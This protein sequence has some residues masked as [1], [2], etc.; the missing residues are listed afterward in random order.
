MTSLADQLSALG[1]Q[2]ASTPLKDALLLGFDTETTGVG[3]TDAIV[4]AS[5]VLRDPSTGFDGDRRGDW[6]INPHRTISPAASAV[7]GF[8]NEYL[9][10]HGQQPQE[11]LEQIATVVAL[12][13]NRNI[14]LLAYNA[15]FDVRMLQHDLS[16]WHLPGLG[17]R[18]SGLDLLVVDPLV[19]DRAI[20][21]RH[22]KR[23]LTAA[24]EYYHVAP[25]GDFHDAAIDT[26]AALDL[27]APMCASSEELANLPLS[28]VMDWQRT[29]HKKWADSF[30]E[31]LARKGSRQISTDWL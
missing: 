10:E 15:P 23:T 14:P 13:Q 3:P 4:S 11:A 18:I 6:V 16:Y 31:W 8:T 29:A 2:P 9:Q 25:H 12:A 21:H 19:I 24:S 28:Q 27:I 17:A 22:G 26:T 5:L 20:C 7:N 1:A 30:N